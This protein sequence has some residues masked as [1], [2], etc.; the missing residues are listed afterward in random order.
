MITRD[1]GYPGVPTIT[2]EKTMYKDSLA[3]HFG[4]ICVMLWVIGLLVLIEII[5]A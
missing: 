1:P 4:S 2:K 5:R 3:N